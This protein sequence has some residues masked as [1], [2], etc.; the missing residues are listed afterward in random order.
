[1]SGPSSR[2]RVAASDPEMG[3]SL[4]LQGAPIM[5]KKLGRRPW[6]S[7]R[8]RPGT[9]PSFIRS[10][11]QLSWNSPP[12]RSRDRRSS[13]ETRSRFDRWFPWRC[14]AVGMKRPRH[15]CSGPAVYRGGAYRGYG[16]RGYGYRPY[17]YGAAAVGAAAARR[18]WIDEYGTRVCNSY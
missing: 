4:Y 2:K 15:K 7:E 10:F 6:F 8:S 18:C 16:Y 1:M 11:S 17:G 14:A 13:R 5:A 9:R 3:E 12:Y